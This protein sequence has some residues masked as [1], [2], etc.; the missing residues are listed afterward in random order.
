MTPTLLV[1]DLRDGDDRARWHHVCRV[2]RHR[3]DYPE[4]W[5]TDLAAIP[6]DA[7]GPSRVGR[8]HGG[9]I[10]CVD[11]RVSAV[12]RPGED[13]K[14]L[15]MAATA[16][17]AASRSGWAHSADRAAFR[18]SGSPVRRA[19]HLHG[20]K[21]H[22]SSDADRRASVPATAGMIGARTGRPIRSGTIAAGPCSAAPSSTR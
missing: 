13:V 6:K 16:K 19:P 15:M 18:S 14:R 7:T 17:A 21:G 9:V 12:R 2:P 8:C 3:L 20:P 22:R 5:F 4:D 11:G 1:G 10:K